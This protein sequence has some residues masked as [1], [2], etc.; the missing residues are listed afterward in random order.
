[1]PCIEYESF[2]SHVHTLF[3]FATIESVMVSFQNKIP[4][5]VNAGMNAII[6][7]VKIDLVNA[8]GNYSC[9]NITKN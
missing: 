8:T 9:I 3:T 5:S 1:M 6:P 7:Y 4:L 2:R